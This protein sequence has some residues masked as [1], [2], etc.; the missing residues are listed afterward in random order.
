MW[1][2]YEFLK[3]LGTTSLQDQKFCDNNLGLIYLCP[4]LHYNSSGE[5]ELAVFLRVWCLDFKLSSKSQA[6]KSF[7]N[8]RSFNTLNK[9]KV[10]LLNFFCL[11][12]LF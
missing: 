3:E 5:H 1:S 9:C 10:V 8:L 4:L 6:R 2:D 7:I 12:V 11:F